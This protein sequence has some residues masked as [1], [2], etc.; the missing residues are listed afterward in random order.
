MPSS[1]RL[2]RTSRASAVLIGAAAIFCV[3]A[4]LLQ[5]EARQG[6]LAETVYDPR[7]YSGDGTIRDAGFWAHPRY[8]I[9]FPSFAATGAQATS[10][11]LSGIP[12][13]KMTFGLRVLAPHLQ[14]SR[15]E[16]LASRRIVS[17]TIHD[18]IGETIAS[19]SAPI[20]EWEC[21]YSASSVY[22]WHMNL[23]ELQLG[24]KCHLRLSVE[25]GLV[26]TALDQTMLQPFLTGGGSE[27]P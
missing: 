20:D 17:V 15:D 19:H 26:R 7:R 9:A 21:A 6:V 14:E 3:A 22:F 11:A 13:A 10:Y 27:L 25:D 4:L 24:S 8:E 5:I 18:G 2:A 16:L 1:D 23:R 12:P